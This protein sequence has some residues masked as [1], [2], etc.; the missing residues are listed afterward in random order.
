MRQLKFRTPVVCQNGHRAFYYWEIDQRDTLFMETHAF[1][2]EKEEDCGCPKFDVNEGWSRAGKDKQFTGRLD[3]KG[4]EVY[5]G[6]IVKLTSE[7]IIKDLKFS[8]PI[9]VIAFMRGSWYISDV[10]N[11]IFRDLFSSECEVIGSTFLTEKLLEEEY[12]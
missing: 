3:V 1:G 9:G 5:E 2:V 8:S 6:A 4:I 12:D 10:V 7:S 11:N